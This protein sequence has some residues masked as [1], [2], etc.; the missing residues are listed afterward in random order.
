LTAQKYGLRSDFCHRQRD[1]DEAQR[2]WEGKMLVRVVVVVT[3]IFIVLRVV[4]KLGRSL[5][6]V[7]KSA[8]AVRKVVKC[9][10][11][12]VHFPRDEAVRFEGRVYCSR[13]HASDTK[14]D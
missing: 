11:C 1:V 4:R 13:A 2:A 6:P 5:K 12:S 14:N 7:G 10:R 8:T 3:L 9:A